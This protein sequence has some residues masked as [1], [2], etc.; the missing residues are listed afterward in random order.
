MQQTTTA[1][2][3]PSS[4]EPAP[5]DGRT[6]RIATAPVDHAHGFQSHP[7]RF[8]SIQ[9]GEHQQR[10]N[11]LWEREL[12]IPQYR[13]AAAAEK[14]LTLANG[15]DAIVDR[16]SSTDGM[17]KTKQRRGVQITIPRPAAK[18]S[19]IARRV[20]S[21]VGAFSGRSHARQRLSLTPCLLLRT[22]RGVTP[23][24]NVHGPMAARSTHHAAL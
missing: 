21:C 8:A 6:R 19:Q 9:A 22:P 11:S 16:P 5:S 23:S 7:L 15:S 1:A 2:G 3:V 4:A 10:T 17:M 18:R 24:F 12:N 20:S 13:Q 14:P